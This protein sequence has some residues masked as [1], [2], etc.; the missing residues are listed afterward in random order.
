M[1]T[2]FVMT[3]MAHLWS[4]TL[5]EWEAGPDRAVVSWFITANLLAIWGVALATGGMA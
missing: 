3:C 5:L 1:T 4:A 2:L